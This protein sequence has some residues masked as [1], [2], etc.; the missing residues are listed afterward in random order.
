MATHVWTGATNTSYNN[1][2]NWTGGIPSAGGV[3]TFSGS[4]NCVMDVATAAVNSW[5][6]TG[7]TGI[8]SSTGNIRIDNAADAVCLFAGGTHTWSGRLLLNPA[9]TKTLSLT[10]AGKLGACT[11]ITQNGA[12]TVS[13]QDNLTIDVSGSNGVIYINAAGTLTTNNYSIYARQ[14]NSTISGTRT[15]N[16]GTSVI[17]LISNTY[18]IYL[19]NGTINIA[20][21]NHEFVLTGSGLLITATSTNCNINKITC[22]G[23]SVVKLTNNNN[24]IKTLSFT[25]TA[26]QTC[27][28]ELQSNVTIATSLTLNGNSAINRLLVQSNTIGTARTITLG[29]SATMAS[30]S[31]Y[32][33]LQDITMSGG[34][35]NER[36][37]QTNSKSAGDCGGNTGIAFTT[38]ADQT[39]TNADGGNWSLSTNWTSRVPLPQDNVSLNRGGNYNSGVTITADMPR[40]GKNIDCTGMTWTGTA[41]GFNIAYNRSA[42]LYGDLTFISGI[43]GASNGI[44]CIAGRS[45]STITTAGRLLS[46]ITTQKTPAYRLIMLDALNTFYDGA[47][48]A[49]LVTNGYTLT[50]RYFYLSTPGSDLSNSTI[51]HSSDGFYIVNGVT[52]TNVDIY[53]THIGTNNN[54]LT[55][56]NNTYR[57]IIITPS[58]NATTFS[59][60]F[61][62]RNMTMASAGAKTVKFTKSNTV[63]LTGNEFLSGT[64]GALIT[65]DTNDGTGTW[66][67]NKTTEIIN[68]DYLNLTR[69]AASGGAS[70][71][72]GPLSHSTDGGGNTGWVFTAAP[73]SGLGWIPLMNSPNILGSPMA[74]AIY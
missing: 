9:S 6:M 48:G 56:G 35:A 59:G 12:G 25:G 2:G 33:D 64:A 28:L 10:S 65:I 62:F 7:Y 57:D 3:V 1:A 58:A 50:V 14:L 46:F 18:P 55:L 43:T 4:V 34:A 16:L 20:D 36:D 53:H 52:C 41:I 37:F 11:G 27:Y 31:N 49:I 5:D 71:Y 45:D 13:L 24:T 51:I 54:Y 40:L 68:S 39:F 29:A 30:V 73:P 69:S 17:T 74:G 22:S 8:L 60:A 44:I 67:L 26:S 47:G 32:V 61:T 66:T 70:F 72:A 23:L 19:L 63:T 15:F 42:T 38:A 21:T